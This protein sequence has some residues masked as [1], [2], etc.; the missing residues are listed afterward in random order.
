MIAQRITFSA[1]AALTLGLTACAQPRPEAPPP[2]DLDPAEVIAIVRE[3]TEELPDVTVTDLSVGRAKSLCGVIRRPNERP[4]AFYARR[5]W[6]DSSEIVVVMPLLFEERLW[7]TES[8]RKIS[9][10][11]MRRCAQAG[12]PLPPI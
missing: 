10:H 11:A 1:V 12:S 7:S 5:D 4:H 3:R 6:D 8:N 9:D 2:A